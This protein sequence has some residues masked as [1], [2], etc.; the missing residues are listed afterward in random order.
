MTMYMIG[1]DLQQPGKNYD[2]LHRAIK[3]LSGTWCHPLDS[4]WI[5]SHP[6]PAS[7]IRDALLPH[8][9]ANDVL[10]VAGLTGE[11]AWRS[12][13]PTVSNWLKAA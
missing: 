2:N 1:Y 9:D 6:G 12:L 8:I 13:S 7:A 11:S 3:G 4:T 10:L 5:V